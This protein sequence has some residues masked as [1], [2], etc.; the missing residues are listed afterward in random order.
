MNP[1]ESISKFNVNSVSLRLELESQVARLS[2]Q[3]EYKETELQHHKKKLQQM[4][5]TID[6]DE[7]VVEEQTKVG[8]NSEALQRE[9]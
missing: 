4:Q 7:R 6:K 9:G 2:A 3:L 8:L 1:N 5:E